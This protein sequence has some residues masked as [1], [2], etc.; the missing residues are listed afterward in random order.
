MKK[1]DIIV[2]AAVLLLAAS[3]FVL[4]LTRAGAGDRV[5]VVRQDGAEVARIVLSGLQK[6]VTVT[7]DGPYQNII[8]ADQD[9]VRVQSATCP[10]QTCVQ[11]GLL[12]RP[13]Q[14]AVC[15]ENKMTLTIEGQD[16]LDAVVQ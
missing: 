11:T 5:A 10:H 14:T 1:G 4:G 3:V 9:G 16:T 2:C 7:V 15:L 6:P 12:T 8:V 13:G